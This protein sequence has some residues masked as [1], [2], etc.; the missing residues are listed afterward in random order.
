MNI[1]NIVTR[2]KLKLGLLSKVMS[3]PFPN[4]DETIVT[5]LNDITTPVFS[6]YCPAREKFTINLY[7]LE[8]LEKEN[9]RE[10]YLL[11]EFKTRKLLY[12]IDLNYDTSVLSGFGYYSGGMPLMQGSLLNQ[13]MLSNAGAQVMNLFIPKLTFEFTPPRTVTIYNAYSSSKVVFELGFEQDKSLAGIPET[14]R[15]SYLELALLDV[16]ENLYPTLKYYSEING[17]IGNINLRLD[18]WS[19]AENERKELITRLDDTYHLD[20]AKPIYYI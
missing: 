14:A 10:T 18:E 2:I 7:D 4:L 6:Q 8:L 5:I 9:D 16:K 20:Y 1:S 11:P 3:T 13:G 12:V 15:E 17:V 19:Q